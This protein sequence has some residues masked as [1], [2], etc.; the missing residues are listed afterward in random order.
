MSEVQI[1][2]VVPH[3]NELEIQRDKYGISAAVMRYNIIGTTDPHTADAQLA[4]KAFNYILGGLKRDKTE[5]ERVAHHGF[6]GVVNYVRPE[7]PENSLTYSFDTT[8]ETQHLT[9][10]YETVSSLAA[11]GFIAPDNH[12]AIGVTD[13]DIQGVDVIVPTLNFSINQSRTGRIDMAF[14]REVSQYTGRVN[15]T[16]FL[17]FDGG[18]VL[19]EGA[20]GS[21]R[22]ASEEAPTFE[23][24]YKFKISPNIPSMI[25][26]G[27]EV[28][29][30]L[31]WDYFWVQ[32]IEIE[33]G[34][35]TIMN[36]RPIAGYVERVYRFADLNAL[37]IETGGM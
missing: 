4:Q 19:F 18:E 7:F 11:P 25:I 29:E 23:V 22:Y 15:E 5:I 3:W 17:G 6:E 28:P 2:R 16:P 35:Q 20:S 30:K 32:Y 13:D 31:G 33:D 37:G 14:I 24:T 27:I 21:Q 1:I 10:S 9:T 26:S 34:E 36:K 8:G 12:G